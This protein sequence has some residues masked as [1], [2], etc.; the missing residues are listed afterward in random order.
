MVNAQNLHQP[1]VSNVISDL[2]PDEGQIEQF[3]RQLAAPWERQADQLGLMEVRFLAEGRQPQVSRFPMQCCDRAVD[4]IVQQNSAG[5]NAYVCV[6]PVNSKVD[7][8]ANKAATDNDI[9]GAHFVFVDCDDLGGA[10]RVAKSNLPYDMCVMTGQ[11]PFVR[12][13]FYWQL[14]KPLF[15]LLR[16]RNIQKRLIA[17]YETDA[18]IHNPSRIM[19]IAGT[20]TY[21]SPIKKERGYVSELATFQMVGA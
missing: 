17:E 8:A 3:L 1:L 15:D 21:P 11:I 14:Q 10:E 7:S 18:V 9:L 2:V 4:D 20:I 16:W 12:Q 19:R 13:H 5:M 6:N